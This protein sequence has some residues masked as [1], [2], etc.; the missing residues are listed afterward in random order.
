[1]PIDTTPLSNTWNKIWEGLAQIANGLT[2]LSTI[3]DVLADGKI[4]PGE[5]SKLLRANAQISNGLADLIDRFI[6]PED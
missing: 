6:P 3:Q 5:V 1:M 2:P 4:E